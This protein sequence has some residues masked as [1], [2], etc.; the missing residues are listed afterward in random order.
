MHTVHNNVHI[1][2]PIILRV[3]LFSAQERRKNQQRQHKPFTSPQKICVYKFFDIFYC[4]ICHTHT[5]TLSLLLS[6]EFKLYNVC[7][8]Y[9]NRLLYVQPEKLKYLQC[10]HLNIMWVRNHKIYVHVLIYIYTF[11]FQRAVCILGNF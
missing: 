2:M 9:E 11:N 4:S 8:V 6:D 5:H 1:T 3:K 7:A 10:V